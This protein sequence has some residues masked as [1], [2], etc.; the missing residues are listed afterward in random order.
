[1]VHSRNDNRQ[2]K[3]KVLGEKI[4]PRHATSALVQLMSPLFRSVARRW[5]LTCY[6]PIPRNIPEERRPARVN[7]SIKNSIQIQ[8]ILNKLVRNCSILFRPLSRSSAKEQRYRLSSNE[9][10]NEARAPQCNSK[11][12]CTNR[13]R[14]IFSVQGYILGR[15]NSLF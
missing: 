7:S 11:A 4:F 9:R 3:R 1:M 10:T 8:S 14:V 13:P 2:W 5:F 15:G 6:K 12:W